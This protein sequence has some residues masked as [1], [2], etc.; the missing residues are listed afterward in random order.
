MKV[1]NN[2][3]KP[4]TQPNNDRKK[5]FKTAVLAYAAGAAANNIITTAYNLTIN[6]AIASLITTKPDPTL[7]LSAKLQTA[8]ENSKLKNTE[9]IDIAKFNSVSQNVQLKKTAEFIEKE[10]KNHPFSK[11]IAN[12]DNPLIKNFLQ[13]KYNTIAYLLKE[14]KNAIYLMT[15]NK[16]LINSEKAGFAGFHEIGHAMNRHLSHFGRFLQTIRVPSAMAASIIPTIALL[17]NKRTDNN[18][19]ENF[20]QKTTAF[21]KENV[22]KLT[23][24]AFVPILTEEAMASV[25][26]Q[27][28]AK[29]VLP[30]TLMKNVTKANLAGFATYIGLALVSG[31]AA[32]TGNKLRDKIVEKRKG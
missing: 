25:K 15:T 18:P 4:V 31:F 19:P 23:A 12:C 28:L 1:T 8:L 7:N 11:I 30:K 22:G 27:K 16:I 14:G 17:T 9:L 26:G 6:N 3:T 13:K 32:Y 5:N 21:I 24:I 20:W 29:S 2:T 10:Y